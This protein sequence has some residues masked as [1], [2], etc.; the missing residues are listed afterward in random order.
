M[1]QLDTPKF[2]G[3]YRRLTRGSNAGRSLGVGL[4]IAVVIAI[5]II[6]SVVL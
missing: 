6:A 1:R 3:T 4:L 2:C 5:L